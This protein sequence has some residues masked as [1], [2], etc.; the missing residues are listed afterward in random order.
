MD[1]VLVLSNTFRDRLD[2]GEL[3]K[4][5]F[6]EIRFPSF[7]LRNGEESCMGDGFGV[8][9]NDVGAELNLMFA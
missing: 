7:E 6:V 2:D 9:C 3:E 8:G 4:S 5:S 1:S